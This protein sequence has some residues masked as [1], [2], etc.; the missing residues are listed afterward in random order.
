MAQLGI[1]LRPEDLD[2]S[3]YFFQDDTDFAICIDYADIKEYDKEKQD[4]VSIK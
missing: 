1:G 2:L 3:S 4:F